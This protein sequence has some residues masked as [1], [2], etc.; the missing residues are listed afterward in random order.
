MSTSLRFRLILRGSELTGESFHLPWN[1]TQVPPIG[2]K[3]PIALTVPS[4]ISGLAHHQP[5]LAKHWFGL[6]IGLPP[7]PGRQGHSFQLFWGDGIWPWAFQVLLPYQDPIIKHHKDDDFLWFSCYLPLLLTVVPMWLPCLVYD[8]INKDSVPP[9]RSLGPPSPPRCPAAPRQPGSRSRVRH[10]VPPGVAT[11]CAESLRNS[12]DVRHNEI[13]SQ[14]HQLLWIR[15]V[16]EGRTKENT[17]I[18]GYS[19]V[20]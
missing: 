18:F 15:G 4:V 20:S 17:T 10:F 6:G 7:F 5:V 3:K 16:F 19:G 11:I 13:R 9:L 12:R 2:L 14:V 1:N 8:I